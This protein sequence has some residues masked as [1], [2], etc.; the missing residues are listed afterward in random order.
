MRPVILFCLIIALVPTSLWAQEEESALAT[1]QVQQWAVGL[2]TMTLFADDEPLLANISYEGP[3]A[4]VDLPPGEYDLTFATG[5][6]SSEGVIYELAGVELA[7]QTTYRITLW[8]ESTP[9]AALRVDLAEV[10]PNALAILTTQR[11]QVATGK[12][13]LI[14]LT[15]LGND[16]PAVDLRMTD[17]TILVQG[18]PLEA[19]ARLELLPGPYDLLITV[20]DDPESVLVNLEGVELRAGTWYNLHLIGRLAD[21]QAGAQLLYSEATCLN[22]EGC[23]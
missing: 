17:G 10:N 6:T 20:T 14:T 9:E 5:Q 22:P 4:F 7:A 23:P 15:H 3:L 16:V 2:P 21:L 12:A 18:L 8:G 1:L 19:T 13:V 11:P